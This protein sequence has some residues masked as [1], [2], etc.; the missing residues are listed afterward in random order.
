MNVYCTV[1]IHIELGHQKFFACRWESNKMYLDW[2]KGLR[3]KWFEKFQANDS[4]KVYTLFTDFQWNNYEQVIR[5]KIDKM[6]IAWND[7]SFTAITPYALL[8]IHLEHL[9]IM[10]KFSSLI[11]CF[12]LANFQCIIRCFVKF[13]WSL[14][15]SSKLKYDIISNL[16]PMQVSFYIP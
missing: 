11:I 3:T 1:Y 7:W 15:E 10:E 2:T 8:F 16:S 4:V 9:F 6:S 13:R 14:N 5:L 12:F